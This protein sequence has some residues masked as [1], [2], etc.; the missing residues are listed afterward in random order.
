MKT[1][2]YLGKTV[3]VILLLSTF[4]T[5]SC[6]QIVKRDSDKIKIAYGRD[7]QSLKKGVVRI[8]A[9]TFEDKDKAGTG[10]IVKSDGHSVYIATAS[11][12]VAGAREIMVE[13][14]TRR[15]RQVPAK[16]VIM[17][18]E[19]PRG[20]AV[21]LIEEKIPAGLSLAVLSLDPAVSLEGG[22]TIDIIGCP[23]LVRPWSVIK[24]NV[25]SKAGEDIVLQAAIEEGI[26]GSPLLR[27]GQ[28]VGLVTVLREPYGYA[29][30]AAIIHFFLK[31]NDIEVVSPPT[32]IK[33]PIYP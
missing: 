17:Q 26:S 16:V 33:A 29:K 7:I 22:E 2:A 30:H 20:L 18:G 1:D 6:K 25:V 8:S 28:V 12:V 32:T 13:F 5:H 3:L 23:R 27:N 14:Y 9:V 19:D 4:I 10:F 15:N 11:H 24:G 31:E 21:L